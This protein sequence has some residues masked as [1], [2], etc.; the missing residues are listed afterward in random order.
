M[1]NGT[2]GDRWGKAGEGRWN[3]DLGDAEPLPALRGRPGATHAE[4]VLPRFDEAGA[5]HGV[6]GAA[7]RPAGD[8][9]VRSDAR[10]V[11]RGTRRARRLP[12]GA[13]RGRG[14]ALYP[15]LAGGDHPVSAGAVV[16]AARE[17]TR[18]AEQPR[19]RC[20]IVMGAGTNH[21]FHSDTI[22]RSRG[23][24]RTPAAHR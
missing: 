4:V 16:R 5:A 23:T 24:R 11:R 10:P 9:G 15:R 14:H 21:W 12:A 20:V 2:L 13:V 22:H 8:D 7:R 18:T 1:P 19:G 17:F 6:G 3:P